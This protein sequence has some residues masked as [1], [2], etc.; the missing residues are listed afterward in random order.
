MVCIGRPCLLFLPSRYL[1][2]EHV[3]ENG[4]SF[5][6]KHLSSDYGKPSDGFYCCDS[7]S[8]LLVPHNRSCRRNFHDPRDD[9]VFVGL[10]DR[11]RTK[12]SR[13]G[14]SAVNAENDIHFV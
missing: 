8:H 5:T 9:R 1:G 3:G 13:S 4:S 14:T 10:V 12:S 7:L 11:M 2:T 6:S